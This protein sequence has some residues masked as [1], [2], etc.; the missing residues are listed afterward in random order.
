LG[1]V[2]RIPGPV[3]SHLEYE[4]DVD[5]AGE[6]GD[7]EVGC[8]RWAGG[9][10]GVWAVLGDGSPEG[11]AARDGP[12][13]GGGEG[14]GLNSEEMVEGWAGDGSH[15]PHDRRPG[16]VESGGAR[17]GGEVVG[18]RVDAGRDGVDLPAVLGEVLG[19][20]A[21]ADAAAAAVL[22]RALGDEQEAL[23]RAASVS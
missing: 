13:G 2:V 3:V 7:E 16:R 4:R 15:A 6:A 9:D 10:D 22:E 23:H 18:G 20:V 1:V 17:G 14:L 11:S 8:D 21:P 19:E 5:F 12:D